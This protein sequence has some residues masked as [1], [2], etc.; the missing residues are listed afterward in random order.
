MIETYRKS[1]Y[2][3]TQGGHMLLQKL[4]ERFIKRLIVLRFQR[5]FCGS[6]KERAVTQA[7]KGL[8]FD[9]FPEYLVRFP[10][11]GRVGCIPFF[12]SCDAFAHEA[13][14]GKAA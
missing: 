2:V 14:G 9:L 10:K 8:R 3:L 1:G 5:C 13:P 7:Q 11:P 4:G 6:K 12:C